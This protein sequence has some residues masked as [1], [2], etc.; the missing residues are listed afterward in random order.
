MS[1]PFAGWPI[2][3]GAPEARAM[4]LIGSYVCFAEALRTG[5]P[6]SSPNGESM[7][8]TELWSAAGA[9]Q[10]PSFRVMSATDCRAAAPPETPSAFILQM[11]AAVASPHAALR[12]RFSDGLSIE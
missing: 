10:R 4:V 5:N 12:P 1:L 8:A 9:S 11:R 3:M 6:T 7:R 2:A